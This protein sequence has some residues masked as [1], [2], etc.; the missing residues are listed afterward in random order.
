MS[1]LTKKLWGALP[2]LAG[3]LSLILSVMS[4]LIVLW[5]FDLQQPGELRTAALLF[6]GTILSAP[7]FVCVFISQRLHRALMWLLACASFTGAYFAMRGGREVWS[8]LRQPFVLASIAI[9]VLV[10]ISFRLKG[11]P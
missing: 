5:V 10:E 3:L 11:K 7:L 2:A 8:P 9:A 1:T 4:M 6:L